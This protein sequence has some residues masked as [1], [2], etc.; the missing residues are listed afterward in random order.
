MTYSIP[1]HPWYGIPYRSWLPPHLFLNVDTSKTTVLPAQ[2]L[3]MIEE[4]SLQLLL[5]TRP[6]EHLSELLLGLL[7]VDFQLQFPICTMQVSYHTLQSSLHSQ[8]LVP[9]GKLDALHFSFVFHPTEKEVMEILS[10]I[11]SHRSL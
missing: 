7:Q 10:K 1:L 9:Q 5:A 4:F 11:V 8:Y 3:R 2:P 6:L